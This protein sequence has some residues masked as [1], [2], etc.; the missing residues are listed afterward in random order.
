MRKRHITCLFLTIMGISGCADHAFDYTQHIKPLSKPLKLPD[1]LSR[2]QIAPT[3]T[4]DAQKNLPS[5][6]ALSESRKQA[7]V[8]LKPPQYDQ[9]YNLAYI[10]QKNLQIVQTQLSN[11]SKGLVLMVSEPPRVT[12]HLIINT[13][14]DNMDWQVGS[15]VH[16][17]TIIPVE[18]QKESYH[19]ILQRHYDDYHTLVKLTTTSGGQVKQAIT[20]KLLSDLNQQL[21]GQHLSSA[22][23]IQWLPGVIVTQTGVYFELITTNNPLLRMWG[24]QV[25][26]SQTLQQAVESANMIQLVDH[27]RDDLWQIQYQDKTYQLW[28]H[29]TDQTWHDLPM[30]QIHVLTQQG[31][32]VSQAMARKL[33]ARI[34]ESIPL[35]NK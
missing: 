3:L 5:E 24:R 21:S 6:A 27:Q 17:S 31:H 32:F 12:G 4:F 2:K 1:T 7:H 20:S 23:L 25:K 8:V 26:V 18:Y 9:N 15:K 35:S 33:L 19:L 30:W 11:E 22:H 14:K 13:L 16:L 10:R 29:Q 28:I 34:T